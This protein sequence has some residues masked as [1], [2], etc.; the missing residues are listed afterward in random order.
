LSHCVFCPEWDRDSYLELTSFVTIIDTIL[1]ELKSNSALFQR[2]M[3]TEAAD[4]AFYSSFPTILLLNILSDTGN[5]LLKVV[6]TVNV[7]TQNS[8]IVKGV[9]FDIRGLR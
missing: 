8:K 7:L 5:K 3:H 9:S 6:S 4:L 2:K 1:F